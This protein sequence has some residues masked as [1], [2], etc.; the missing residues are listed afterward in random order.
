MRAVEHP[1]VAGRRERLVDPPEV[2][3]R[4]FLLGGLAEAGVADTHRAARSDH[5]LDDAALARG[6]HALQHQQH[7]PA[8]AALPLA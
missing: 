4:A 6:V 1:D 2:V 7:R 8:V 3:V 5:M